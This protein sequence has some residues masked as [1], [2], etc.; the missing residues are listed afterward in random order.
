MKKSLAVAV[1]AAV[2]PFGAQAQNVP[3]IT[4]NQTTAMANV[5]YDFM[6]DQAFTP[7]IGAGAGIAPPSR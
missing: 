5:Y 2:L 7:Y 4:V 6:S 3:G 1:L